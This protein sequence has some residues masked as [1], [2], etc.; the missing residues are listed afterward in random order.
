MYRIGICDDEEACRI[1]I[2]ESIRNIAL[3]ND[4]EV[5]IIQYESGIQVMDCEKPDILILDIE[6]EHID[7][8][9]VRDLLEQ[10]DNEV[11]IIFCT[12]HDEIMS[13]AY[14][15]IDV[16]EYPIK[17]IVGSNNDLMVYIITIIIICLIG[18][19]I[20]QFKKVSS[21]IARI[22]PIYFMASSM[23]EIINMGIIVMTDDIILPGQDRLKIVINVLTMI[24]F[25]MLGIFGIVFMF[26]GAYKKQL[27]ID[28]KIKQNYLIIQKEHY[29]QLYSHMREIRKIKHDMNAHINILYNLLDTEQYD[30][31]VKYIYD[32]KM[33]YDIGKKLESYYDN[34]II[35]AIIYYFNQ[36]NP[37]IK[38]ICMGNFSGRN[39]ISDLTIC[40]ILSNCISNAVEACNRL[41]KKKK[42]IM[43]NISNVRNYVV[44]M[45]ENPIEWE[46]D[47]SKLGRYTSKDDRLSHGYG[48]SNIIDEVRLC[49]GNYNFCADDGKFSVSI[50]IKK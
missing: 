22:D 13:K 11:L 21:M 47:I 5:K 10:T 29:S 38:F 46:V 32:I 19:I 4:I 9:K 35:D 3:K 17:I 34:G 49:E 50:A 14:G 18:K 40:T 28:N 2:S 31:A 1:K 8:L 20:N 43:I 26:L 24:S 30:E 44:I 41:Q 33:H 37:L 36:K 39:E 23:I 42:E 6:M 16:I 48:V 45:I 25:V 15:Y 27:E 12:S 7:G